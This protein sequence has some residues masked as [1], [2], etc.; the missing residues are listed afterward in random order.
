M[1]LSDECNLSLAI[2]VKTFWHILYNRRWKTSVTQKVSLT[3]LESVNKDFV[4][5]FIIFKLQS[6]CFFRSAP[7]YLKDA[8]S[9][10]TL[11]TRKGTEIV[12]ALTFWQH[13]SERGRIFSFF[14]FHSLPLKVSHSFSVWHC[15]LKV[16]VADMA[17]HSYRFWNRC[18]NDDSWSHHRVEEVDCRCGSSE[19]HAKVEIATAL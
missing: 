1:Y 19:C 11:T 17:W 3:T 14:L 5:H 13:T 4:R 16:T 2:P 7:I 10:F 18:H 8:I 12:R 6:Q 15:L 9:S